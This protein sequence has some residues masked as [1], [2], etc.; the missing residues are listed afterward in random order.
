MADAVAVTGADGFIGGALCSKLEREGRA[1]A[2]I[3]RRTDGAGAD[4]RIVPDLSQVDAL[5]RAFRGV[6]AVVHLA[7]RAHVLRET[8]DDPAATYAR[9]NVEGTAHVAEAAARAGLRRVVLL[10]SIGVNGIRTSGTPFTEAQSPAPAEPYAASKHAAELRLCEFA[11]QRGLEFT[12]L[13]PPMVY[14][15]G[16]KGNLRRLL[17]LVRS[18]IPLPL[19]SLE[20]RRSLIGVDNLGDLIALCVDHAAARD[21]LFLAAEPEVHSTPGLL[22][23]IAAAMS[24]RSRLFRCPPLLLSASTRLLGYGAEYA[25]LAASLEVSAHKAHRLLGWHPRVDY[26]TG[27]R[28]TVSAFLDEVD[29]VR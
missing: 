11:R 6:R 19:A 18:G 27:L 25:K 2:R 29:A 20:N 10:S 1:V 12:I 9:E 15:P 17:A 4:R 3:V 8:A 14:G 7:G 26:K 21:E 22:E 24:R 16:A 5:A 13:R 23:D 28:Q